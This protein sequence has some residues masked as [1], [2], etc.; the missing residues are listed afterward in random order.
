[1]FLN[2]QIKIHTGIFFA[3]ENFCYID[4]LV[5]RPFNS[6]KIPFFWQHAM[7]DSTITR[8]VNGRD[9]ILKRK[10]RKGCI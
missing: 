8:T 4:N 3:I 2:K 1:L 7:A 5:E 9:S 10:R 6:L